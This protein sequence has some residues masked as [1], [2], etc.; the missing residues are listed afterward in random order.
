MVIVDKD[1]VAKF[2]EAPEERRSPAGTRRKRRYSS[3]SGGEGLAQRPSIECPMPMTN[4][5]SSRCGGSRSATAACRRSPGPTSTSIR[6]EVH[7]LVGDNAAGKSTPHQDAVRR[8]A[9]RRRRRSSSTAGRSRSR[10][11]RTPRRSA[12]RPSIRTSRSPTTSTSPP[13]SSSGARS[14]IG[15]AA[16]RSSICAAWRRSRAKLLARL[17]INIP[18]HAPE[19]ALDVRAASA[20]RSRIARSVYFNA[21]VVILDEPT[22]ALGR[23]GNPQGLELVREMRAQGLAVLMISHNLNH[24]STTPTAFR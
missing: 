5:S 24:V 21:R 19:G 12:S 11:A 16:R 13:T 14:R 6:G 20:S 7:A 18:D 4:R 3:D 1:N 2:H 8:R 9:G 15:R 10:P 22:A 23:R 17:K